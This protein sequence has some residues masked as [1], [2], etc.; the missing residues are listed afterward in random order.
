MESDTPV[1]AP[2]HQ[3]GG[4]RGGVRLST[5]IQDLEL[6]LKSSRE[7]ENSPLHSRSSSRK[8]EHASRNTSPHI[9]SL[10]SNS[11]PYLYLLPDNEFDPIMTS[12]NHLAGH[13]SDISSEVVVQ[14]PPDHNTTCI[15]G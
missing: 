15:K 13:H 4:R 8:V 6:L 7:V 1:M 3:G 12:K 11:K 14:P 10:T 5:S 2:F 9:L